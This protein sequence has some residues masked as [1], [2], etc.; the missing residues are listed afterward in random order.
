[1]GQDVDALEGTKSK[2]EAIKESAQEA[3]EAVRTI[4]QTSSPL[5]GIADVEGLSELKRTLQNVKT[6]SSTAGQQMAQAF[7]APE[8]PL[9]L[10]NAK[11][12]NIY[13][14]MGQTE[15]KIAE[16]TA[17]YSK[18]GDADLSSPEAAKL[19]EQLTRL[20]Q[21]LIALQE[22]AGRTKAQIDKSLDT[23]GPTTL[24]ER[25]QRVAQRLRGLRKESSSTAK[26]VK[27]MG[28]ESEST[29]KK[30]ERAGQ[31][32][33]HFGTRLRS[34]V[35]G[36]LVFNVISRGLRVMQQYLFGAMKTNSQFVSSVAQIK[37]NLLTAFQPIFTAILP[38][39]NA[40]MS[41]LAKA[42]AVIAAFF[43]TLFGATV[44]SSASAAESLYNT[45]QGV[46]GI[47]DAAQSAGKKIKGMLA[48]FDELTVLEQQEPDSG[49]NGGGGGG[50]GGAIAPAFDAATSI[51]TSGM[52]AAIAT[53]KEK[54][55]TLFEPIRASWEEH[56]AGVIQSF[57]DAFS[58]ITGLLGA[59]GAS[60]REV[61]TN[62]TGE[63]IVSN[64]LQIVTNI[65]LA[66]AGLASQFT[67]AWNSGGAGTGIIQGIC[68][69]ALILLGHVN[70]IT[71][72]FSTWATTVDFTAIIGAIGGVV[73]ALKPFAD[74]VGTGL[75]FFFTNVLQP[76]AAWAIEQVIPGTIDLISG[77]FNIL[78]TAIADIQP[79]AT[80]IWENFLL[81]IASWTGGV[82]VDI[83]NGIGDAFKWIADNKVVMTILESIALAIGL[84]TAAVTAWK[85]VAAIATGVTS[86]LGAAIGFLTSPIGIVITII[87]ALIAIGKLLYDNWD[88]IK[89]QAI[90]IWGAIKTWFDE[91]ITAI[92]NFFVGLWNGI[93][94]TFG[95]IGGW[96]SEKF[97]AA[98]EGIKLAF[99]KVGEFFSGVW[100]GIT[101]VFSNITGWFKDK[102]SDAW[103]AV[104]KVFSKG[105]EI[106]AGIKDGILNAL[107]AV[108]NGLITGI[109][110]VISIPFKGINAALR[111]IKKINILGLK[112]FDWIKEFSIPQ[113]P[114]LARGG[115]AY[116]PQLA[117]VGDNPN[118]KTDPEVI[119]PL[120][121]LKG[122]VGGG[123]V[124][125]L[126]QALYNAFVQ[127]FG[128]PSRRY[129]GD[130]VIRTENRVIGR[131]AMQEIKNYLR[132]NGTSPFPV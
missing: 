75:A 85:I 90:K 83:L 98:V 37:G 119:A 5:A 48:P 116:A 69:I 124:D 12:D 111:G 38:A 62:S 31:H 41:A 28:K 17:E 65:N 130:L 1:M 51:D 7:R 120:S 24:G 59:I 15:A 129:E 60:W 13:S 25:L 2:V 61:W 125:T 123:D 58:G 11:L 35:A 23:P 72:G 55:S 118:A 22:Q 49:S 20:E 121:K 8:A 66:V 36:A 103:E 46:T 99:A 104:K 19:E 108:I 95:A 30:L 110:T 21:R 57:K 33:H 18:L 44:T 73:E 76:L 4:G 45:T 42:T 50:G 16:V 107:K 14:Q 117:M 92:G 6:E 29:G 34:I 47:G 52:E 88:V 70:A 81:P 68:D 78:N 109:N 101:S 114:K 128:D 67:I 102:F 79:M 74:A 126:T 86:A 106:F 82:V 9:D 112:P 3:S 10:L 39:L 87:T 53:I 26:S 91:T 64:I 80:W 43:S 56:G 54:L 105:G 96:F 113:I 93:K 132:E 63:A 84:V 94:E 100:D 127:Y 77:A 115:L 71:T 97:T 27:T 40:L 32:A 131:I 89:E 122:M